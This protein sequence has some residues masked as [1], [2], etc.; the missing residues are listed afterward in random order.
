LDTGESVNQW[1]EHF[2]HIVRELPAIR[3]AILVRSPKTQ[4]QNPPWLSV[5]RQQDCSGKTEL[6]CQE[7]QKKPIDCGS[8][9]RT[10]ARPGNKLDCPDVKPEFSLVGSRQFHVAAR[11]GRTG[12]GK[13]LK[14]RQ[15]ALLVHDSNPP[16]VGFFVR[17]ATEGR[18]NAWR[19]PD[20]K[21]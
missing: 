17:L 8:Q 14:G 10:H 4:N 20:A 7:T 13:H 2:L 16:L 6:L 1:P 5:R 9:S 11:R 12:V 3:R 19:T 21:E 18:A 15:L